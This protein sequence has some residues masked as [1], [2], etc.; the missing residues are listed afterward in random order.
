M[1]LCLDHLVGQERELS[2]SVDTLAQTEQA[3][4]RLDCLE[5]SAQVDTCQHLQITLNLDRQRVP[6]DVE[7]E[8]AQMNGPPPLV[9]VFAGPIRR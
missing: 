1:E 5:S 4:K 6:E 3:L 7:R 9:C 8:C 2:T